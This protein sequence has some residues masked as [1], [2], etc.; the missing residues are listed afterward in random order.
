MTSLLVGRETRVHSHT[1]IKEYTLAQFLLLFTF[2]TFPDGEA[3]EQNNNSE[4]L[5]HAFW[6]EKN[7]IGGKR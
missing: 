5:E 7:Y 3:N 4:L 2:I 1:Q 6:P